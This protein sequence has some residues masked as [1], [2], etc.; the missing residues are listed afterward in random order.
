MQ[1]P[2]VGLNIPS[3]CANLF[4]PNP[5]DRI[6]AAYAKGGANDFVFNASL[7]NKIYDLIKIHASCKPHVIFYPSSCR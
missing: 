1:A 5:P 7:N 3:L 4:T 2:K 6:I